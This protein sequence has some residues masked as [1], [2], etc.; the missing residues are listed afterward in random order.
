MDTAGEQRN[1]VS[2][3]P[4][5]RRRFTSSLFMKVAA[6]DPE[7]WRR[8][9]GVVAWYVR[10]SAKEAG[11]PAQDAEDLAQQVC[12]QIAR[13]IG[14]FRGQPNGESFRAWVGA[15]TRHKIADYFRA[16][17]R[18]PEGEPVGGNQPE[19]AQI[20]DREPDSADLPPPRSG[21]GEC[22]FFVPQ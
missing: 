10:E 7:G 3:E 16:R 2:Q 20:T 9:S 6:A 15:I 22:A 17:S 14:D 1:Q 19:L 5:K 11:I 21:T 4:V 13:R 12:I 8:L 18:R